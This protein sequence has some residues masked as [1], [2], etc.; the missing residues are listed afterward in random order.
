MVSAMVSLPVLAWLCFFVWLGVRL[1]IYWVYS[2]RHSE[3][4]AP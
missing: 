2:R 4:A 1:A 3:L